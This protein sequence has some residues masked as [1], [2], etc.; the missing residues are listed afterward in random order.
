M[1]G[2]ERCYRYCENVEKGKILVNR[3]IK[4][5]VQRFRNDLRKSRKKDY[6]YVFDEDKANHF[7]RFAE[8]LK[9]YKDE[10]A[11][12]PLKLEDWQCFI[13]CN[14]YGWVEK[15]TGFR[16]FRKAFVFVARKNGKSTIMSTSALYDLLT[17]NGAEVICCATKREQSKIVY[18]VCRN[19]VRQNDALGKRLRVY[20]STYRIVN[21]QKSGFISAISSL[22]DKADGLNPSIIIADEVAAMKDYGI[23]KTLMSG[24]GS[25]PES[26]C[27]EITSGSD[28]MESPGRTEYERSRDI[29]SGAIED[30]SFFCVLYCLDEEDDWTNPKNYMKANPN[31]DVSISKE[32]LEKQLLEALQNPKLESEFRTKNLG[33]W[34]NRQTAWVRPQVWEKVMKSK[35]K[36]DPKKPYYAVGAIDLSKRR[37]LS[38][39]TVCMYQEGHFFMKHHF[40][41]P[42]EAM[43]EKLQKS[44][45]MWMKWSE[46]GLLTPTPGDSINYEFIYKAM[47][48]EMAEYNISEILYDPYNAAS[49]LNEFDGECELVEVN[50]SIKRL[51]P[52][53]KA[54][55]E[56]IYSRTLVDSNPIIQWMMLNAEVYVDPNDNIKVCKPKKDSDKKVDGIITSLMCVGYIQS[57]KDTDE[58]VMT[59]T[60]TEELHDFL[61]DLKL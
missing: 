52:Y 10:W 43:A 12:H 37:D 49:L 47:R 3:F 57:L 50:Q 2:T 40:F 39:F 55:E 33:Q 26:L 20:T 19:M 38:A 35:E 15:D 30:D 51:S 41:F 36:F 9:L 16:R 23:I 59:N 31:L 29:L 17:T 56:A 44:N 48:D 22:E 53:A 28:N 61:K 8:C 4:Q 54:Y 42:K 14:L 45:E 34:L 32:W 46:K 25:R 27:L 5:A 1:T 13:F 7:I 6:P 24:T 21:P 11:G 58:L 18:D 60:S